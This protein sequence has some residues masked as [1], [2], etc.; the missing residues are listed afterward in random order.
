MCKIVHE[1]II[2]KKRQKN[3]RR[4]GEGT[5]G[6]ETQVTIFYEFEQACVSVRVGVGG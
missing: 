1:N 6:V 4:K 5:S 2:I 3:L